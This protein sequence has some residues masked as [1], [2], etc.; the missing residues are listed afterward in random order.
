VKRKPIYLAFD[1]YALEYDERFDEN[2]EVYHSE[3]LALK[4]TV[5]ANKKLIET[6]QKGYGKGSFVIIKAIKKLRGSHP[7]KLSQDEIKRN[8]TMIVIDK[9]AAWALRVVKDYGLA[10]EKDE[11]TPDEALVKCREGL[12]KIKKAERAHCNQCSSCNRCKPLGNSSL[13]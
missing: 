4:E 2:K 6:P 5:P 11:V 3:L 12:R 7:E 10:G 1:K 8:L 9:D 13:S